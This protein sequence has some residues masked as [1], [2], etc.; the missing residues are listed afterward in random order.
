MFFTQ[1]KL[2]KISSYETV[3]IF[4]MIQYET[5]KEIKLSYLQWIT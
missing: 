4:E 3:A 2:F 5:G 1:S